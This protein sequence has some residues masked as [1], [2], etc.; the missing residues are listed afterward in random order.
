MKATPI[1]RKYMS[2]LSKKRWKKTTKKER[3]AFGNML[4]AA[5]TKTIELVD[6]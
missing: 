3:V 1:I 2:E 5:R 4:V 6:K